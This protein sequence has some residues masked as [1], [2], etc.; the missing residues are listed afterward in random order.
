VKSW[1]YILFQGVAG[2]RAPDE[3]EE[4]GTDDGEFMEEK[5]VG[6]RRVEF[7]VILIER[8]FEIPSNK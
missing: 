5:E 1:A 2:A 4:E 8:S 6:Q 7:I 3:N